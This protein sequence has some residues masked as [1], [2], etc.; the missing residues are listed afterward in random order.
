M[1]DCNGS[2]HRV[3]EHTASLEYLDQSNQATFRSLVFPVNLFNNSTEWFAN[4]PISLQPV[5]PPRLW[6]WWKWFFS[7]LF[8]HGNLLF[9]FTV[10]CFP[11]FMMKHLWSCL[12][13]LSSQ[14]S[15]N[16]RVYEWLICMWTGAFTSILI[17]IV[18][19]CCCV[20]WFPCTRRGAV[21]N[22]KRRQ[23]CYPYVALA[24]PLKRQPFMYNTETFKIIASFLSILSLFLPLTHTITHG[25]FE[26]KV[27]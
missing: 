1:C 17:E 24:R 22:E 8:F 12:L 2:N 4:R 11:F 3:H 5:P 18:V 27:E 20:A 25:S 6:I 16:R 15:P 13:G 19:A 26:R 10:F 21:K 9:C 7:H 23:I 14:F